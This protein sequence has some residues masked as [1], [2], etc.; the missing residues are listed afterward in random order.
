M[1]GGRSRSLAGRKEQGLPRQTLPGQTPAWLL[2]QHGPSGYLALSCRKWGVDL[3][4]LCGT[5]YGSA[6]LSST[7]KDRWAVEALGS[8]WAPLAG[9]GPWGLTQRGRVGT[10]AGRGL[11]GAHPEKPGRDHWRGGG[12]KGLT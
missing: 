6:V 7:A 5:Q 9:Q 3:R 12:R 4:T 10:L 11:R 8:C 2:P 1:E